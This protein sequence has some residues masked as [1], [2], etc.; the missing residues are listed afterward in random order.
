MSE[1]IQTI[2]WEKLI[3]SVTLFRNLKESFAKDRSVLL[4]APGG[5]PWRERF[6]CEVEQN[7]CRSDAVRTLKTLRDDT[8]RTLADLT[9]KVCTEDTRLGFWPGS[10]LGDYLAQRSDA[11]FNASFVWV[12]GIESRTRFEEWQRMAADYLNHV[13]K[14]APHA[15]FVLEYDEKPQK[16]NDQAFDTICYHHTQVDSFI[17]CLSLVSELD[18][19]DALKRYIA[20]LSCNIGKDPEECG[21]LAL[22]GIQMARS[23]QDM[24]QT[25]IPS[26]NRE[27]VQSGIWKAQAQL[28]FPALEAF[29]LSLID[30]YREELEQ[31][32][33]MNNGYGRVITDPMDMDIGNI[34]NKKRAITGQAD[35]KDLDY[36]HDARNKIAHNEIIPFDALKKIL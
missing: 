7:S 17:F 25:V 27:R 22:M 14:G 20:E 5:I 19:S 3:S 6:F 2:W 21:K 33:P 15:V 9:L 10:E 1:N 11:L 30:R 32:L 13:P 29:R 31:V 24:A 36:Y 18:C 23:P 35:K 16:P 8:G 34:L 12:Y 4:Y 28:F 26:V